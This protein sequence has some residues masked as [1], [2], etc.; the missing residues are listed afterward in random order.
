MLLLSR[1]MLW[2]RLDPE[3]Q[4]SAQ[5][6]GLWVQWVLEP[7]RGEETGGWHVRDLCFPSFLLM[8]ST[9]SLVSRLEKCHASF[10]AQGAN[11]CTLQSAAL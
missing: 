1:R 6:S 7:V 5:P 2:G 4:A 9:P 11:A 8:C 3:A 10:P